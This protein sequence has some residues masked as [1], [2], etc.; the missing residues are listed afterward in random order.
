[1]KIKKKLI[2]IVDYKL[3]I[4]LFEYFFLPNFDLQLIQIMLIYSL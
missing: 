2:S 3:T 4:D 1:M